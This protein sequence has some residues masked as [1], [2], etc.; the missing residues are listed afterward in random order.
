MR[1]K[2]VA[3]GFLDSAAHA[4]SPFL[5]IFELIFGQKGAHFRETYLFRIK[6]P[7]R[8][9]II[10]GKWIIFTERGR[11]LTEMKMMIHPETANQEQEF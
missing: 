9:T 8:C 6:F 10:G 5:R 11:F 4:F 7:R 3:L 2:R 1:K